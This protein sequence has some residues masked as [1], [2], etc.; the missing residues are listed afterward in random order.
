MGETD[1]EGDA[2]RKAAMREERAEVY[3]INDAANMMGIS[4]SKLYGLARQK[5]IEVR[6]IDG[7][8]V[9][10]QESILTFLSTLPRLHG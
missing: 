10:P 5:R 8:S 6:K 4:R 3:R 1:S 2:G 7:R 9:V